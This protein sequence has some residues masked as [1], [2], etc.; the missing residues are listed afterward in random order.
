M[1]VLVFSKKRQGPGTGSRLVSERGIKMAMVAVSI[2]P[3][4]VGPSVSDYVAAAVKVL[5][6]YPELSYELGPM[7][8]TIEGDLDQIMLAIRDMQEAVFA[9]GVERVGTV[10]KVDDRRDKPLTLKGKVATVKGK[11]SGE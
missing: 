5:N 2:S 3:S 8:T 4:G 7:F 6:E 10:I 9:Q 1:D 11:M